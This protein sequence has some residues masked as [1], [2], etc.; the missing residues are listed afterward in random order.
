MTF[1]A[2]ILNS[3]STVAQATAER[4]SI[5]EQDRDNRRVC[6]A[7]N[8][9]IAAVVTISGHSRNYL[10]LHE[11]CAD[12]PDYAEF[13]RL[14]GAQA[15]NIVV[16][17]DYDRLWRTDALRAQ[18]M[19]W[20]REHACQVFSINQP[21]EPVAPELLAAGASD[22]AMILEAV[23]GVLAEME[24]RE[25]VRRRKVGIEGRIRRGEHVW[26]PTT[27][28]GFTRQDKA[29]VVDESEWRWLEEMKRWVLEDGLGASGIE[30]RLNRLGVPPP[31]ARRQAVPTQ[32]G[33]WTRKTIKRILTNPLYAGVTRWGAFS[34]DGHHR[35]LFTV[36]EQARVLAVLSGH[37]ARQGVYDDRL[38]SGLA[39]CGYCAH[40]MS[41]CKSFG[42][43]YLRC[44]WH[45]NSRGK[46]CVNNGHSANHVHGYVL[47]AI[48]HASLDRED[49]LS[50][51]RAQ[52]DSA[53]IAERIAGIDAQIAEHQARYGQWSHA[54]EVGI[55]ALGELAE[56]RQRILSGVEALKGERQTCMIRLDS[57]AQAL[58]AM[59]ELGGDMD[60]LAEQT[61]ER[62][63][64][65]IVRLVER[66]V[67]TQGGPPSIY[68]R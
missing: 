39:R 22:S 49:W 10:W 59:E 64:A 14:V 31:G 44:S 60:G 51:R 63:R 52:H 7:R 33:R 6:Q 37:S 46:E 40:A 50:A 23:G 54:Y 29:L 53:Q 36:E 47:N 8:W 41:Y 13:I 48:Y 68:W 3:V 30:A 19:A 61:V 12:S 57:E 66:V 56:H 2:I 58:V 32:H 20:C 26:G 38:L 5:E 67:L 35:A 11:L 55:I 24:N 42:V 21:V 45:T 18:V 43:R 62:Q 1:R 17:R 4:F 65:V 15:G 27:A 9:P 25:R 28:Y 34:N 16:C